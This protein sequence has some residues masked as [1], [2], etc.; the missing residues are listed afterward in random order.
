MRL[1]KECGVS[2]ANDWRLPAADHREHCERKFVGT[3]DT[4]LFAYRS[5]NDKIL[6]PDATATY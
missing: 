3:A 1:T 5:A 4:N 2:R 6:L